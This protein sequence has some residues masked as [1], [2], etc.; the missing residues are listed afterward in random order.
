MR[1]KKRKREGS[2]FGNKNVSSL[3]EMLEDEE[4]AENDHSK[5]EAHLK[6]RKKALMRELF[7]NEKERKMSKSQEKENEKIFRNLF[8]EK[9]LAEYP[10][11]NFNCK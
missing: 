3:N 7:E 10:T 2:D 4:S 9:P 1:E 8:S 5:F 11:N 6:F